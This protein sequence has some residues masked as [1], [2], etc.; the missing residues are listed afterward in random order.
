[1]KT[2]YSILLGLFLLQASNISAQETG[3][4][5]TKDTKIEA[6]EAKRIA[7]EEK[8]AA[9]EEEKAMKALD[10]ADKKQAKREEDE[11]KFQKFIEK[12]EPVDYAN[13]DS[14]KMPN[15]VDLFKGS[16]ELFSTMKKVY[17]YI[18]YIQIETKDTIDAEGIAVTEYQ[19]LDAEGN[20]LGKHARRQNITQ[21][22]LDL[23]NAGLM[24]ANLLLSAPLA[25][26]EAI[27]D[28]LLALTLGKKVK[29]TFASV[30]M[31]VK[32]IPLL[33]A[34][35]GDNKAARKQDENN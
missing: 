4:G 16:N 9:K 1:M 24:S 19:K 17:S 14:V 35:I 27:S 20:E 32:V 34:K 31:A 3:S 22:S 8:K 23:T 30:K 2:L 12:W 21:A 15:T 29:K 10:K 7:K 26:T 13:I 18:D 11:A 33:R 6:Q 5:Q 28:P 25:V